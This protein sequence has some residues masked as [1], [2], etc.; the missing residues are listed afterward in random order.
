MPEYINA[1]KLFMIA[2]AYLIKAEA[3]AR[4]S[5]NDEAIDVLNILRK[6]RGASEFPKAMELVKQERTREMI[7]EG[8]RL[9]DLKRWH[10]GFTRNS[11][12]PAAEAAVLKIPNTIELSKKADDKMFVWEIPLNDLQ[13]NTELVPNW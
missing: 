2:E 5:K 13:T 4:K 1:P 9:F 3:L 8:G 10:M 6:A 12:Q 7:A 11:V